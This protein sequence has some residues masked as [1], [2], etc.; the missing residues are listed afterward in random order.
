MTGI[1]LK[2]RVES[3]LRKEVAPALKMDGGS[4]EVLDVADGVVRLRFNGTCTGCPATIMSLVLMLEQEL[5]A[6]V[7]EVEYLEAVP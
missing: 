5:R 4:L 7:P 1:E 6:R 3:V 2:E